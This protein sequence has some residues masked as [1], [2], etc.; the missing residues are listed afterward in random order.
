MN[1]VGIVVEDLAAATAFFVE[2]GLRVQSEWSAGGDWVGRIIGLEGVR[3]DNAMLE[4]PDG[5]ARLELI[6]FRAPPGP[7]IDAHA[8]SNTPGIRHL[9]FEVED[10]EDVLGRLKAHGAELIGAVE[11]YQDM[12]RLCYV[13]GPEG[14]VLEL[15]EPLGGA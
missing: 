1:H 4:T 15:A 2:L 11:R 6:R 7:A 3:A 9:T 13:R 8:P 5:Q 14:I 12:F 10:L